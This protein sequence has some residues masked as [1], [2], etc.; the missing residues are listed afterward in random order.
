VGN[1]RQP[2]ETRPGG[3]TA[4]NREAV[5]R[6][7]LLELA[8]HGYSALTVE[9]V[10]ERAGVHKT[11]VYRRWGGV[12]GLVVD[13]LQF[14]IDDDWQPDLSGSV[15]ENLLDHVR[16]ALDAFRDPEIGP[17]HTAVV[18]AAFQ[19]SEAIE[20]VHAFFADRFGRAASIITTAIERGELP[21]E[22]EPV[23]VI[24]AV[25]APIY[26]RLFISR[27]TVTETDLHESVLAAV[28][29]ARAGAFARDGLGQRP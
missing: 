16:V 9:A 4:R 27:E 8:G 20:A 7:T 23:A 11:T 17:T 29:A 14:A 1:D 13:A 10:A 18:A 2:G 21:A 15:E 26:F 12:D 5:C 6:A 22:T 28:A 25:M 3:R 19:S 24:R